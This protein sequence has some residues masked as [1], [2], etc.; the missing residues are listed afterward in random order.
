LIS[1]STA[2][3]LTEMPAL[4][5]LWVWVCA[6]L[7]CV[8][9]ALSALHQLN[10]RGYAVA[11]ALG[12]AALLVWR[13]Q[14][15]AQIFPEVRWQKYLRRFRRPFPLA[16]LVLAAMAVLGGVIYAPNN[17]DTLA[18]RLPRTLHWLAAGQWHWIHT[19]FARL[20]IHSVGI[21]WLYAPVIALLNTDRPLFLI[22]AVSFLFLPGLVFSILT[23]LGVRRRV[24]WHWMWLAPTGYG[25]LLQAGGV[26]NDLFCATLVA[27]GI[28]F[29]LRTNAEKSWR[30]FFTSILAMAA[31]TSAKSSNLPMLLPW[32]IILLPS[33]KFLLK[34]PW[35]AAAACSLA[36]FVSTAPLMVLNL[37]HTG[38]MTGGMIA[39]SGI[40]GG[41]SLRFGANV[42]LLITQNFVPPVFPLASQWNQ[43][44]QK[45]LP[46][47]LADKLSQLI[48]SPGCRFELPEMQVE[49]D[50]SL[51]FGLSVL[52]LVGMVAA[53]FNREPGKKSV[54]LTW[55]FA[56][57]ISIVIA[58]A[59]VIEESRWTA[60]GRYLLPYYVPLF[61]IFL[62]GTGQDC[63]VRKRWWRVSAYAVFGLAGILLIIA[64]SR[65]L[66]PAQT[67]VEKLYASR[68]DSRWIARAHDVYT[69][70][71]CR[72][73]AFDPAIAILPPR[74]KCLGMVTG[75]DPEATLW[76]PIGSR[77][78][79]HV[80]P[81]DTP[82]DLK[83]RGIEYI[84]VKKDMFGRSEFAGSF[85]DW[86]QH[87]DA[88]V[89]SKISLVLRATDGAR[90]WYLVKL[91]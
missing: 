74:L 13:K 11:L 88:G 48:E 78:V 83:A 71:H 86:L 66:F 37:E 81:R 49:E 52:L 72:N 50:S 14:T 10:A 82:D 8:G 41:T 80:C 67:V 76:R 23:R 6:Y 30:N 32:G 91:N 2:G 79:E 18:Y 26:G 43:M 5:L 59:A 7:N 65:P 47:Y 40:K 9:W 77:R 56:V 60:I 22:Q 42:V 64:P 63:V 25:F 27:A 61:P 34:R 24:A 54:R 70:Y 38:S 85:E 3:K 69:V 17:Y 16:F 58:F 15:S 73:R 57:K 39:D 35:L 46:P 84:L 1:K 20:N 53:R 29:A 51:G 33:V 36:L 68:P 12:F 75:D 21:E 45:N 4:V 90:D 55:L 28:D 89:I 44:V 19:I 87:M 31:A 62:A